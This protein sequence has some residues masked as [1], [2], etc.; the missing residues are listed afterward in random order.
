MSYKILVADDEKQNRE[1]VKF[2][3]SKNI[4][5]KEF[6]FDEAENYDEL[7]EKVKE[8]EYA[9]IITDNDM[10]DENDGINAAREIRKD[11]RKVPI[12]LVSGRYVLVENEA[13]EAGVT[14]GIQKPY[15]FKELA[16]IVNQNL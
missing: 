7:I 10:P 1:F 5:F 12:I 2:A 6:S 9:V 4:Q 8:N 16:D 3:L 15:D 11:N 13:K 14:D